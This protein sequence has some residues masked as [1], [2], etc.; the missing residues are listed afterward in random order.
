MT[1]KKKKY[2]E[3][4]AFNFKHLFIYL[5]VFM[6]KANLKFYEIPFQQVIHIHWSIVSLKLCQKW[7][8][9]GG[10]LKLT[11]KSCRYII[12]TLL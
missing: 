10:L 9:L 2:F 11:V 8:T 6:F 5:F 7:E 12:T 1:K 4:V 3:E